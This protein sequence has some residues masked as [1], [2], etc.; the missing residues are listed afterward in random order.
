MAG[1]K[2]M[3]MSLAYWRDLAVETLRNPADAAARLMTLNLPREALW[4]A[5]VLV[6]VLNT[7]IYTLT[8][9]M[10]PAPTQIPAMLD[11]PVVFFLIVAGGL[12]LSIHAI[13]WV[14]RRLGGS[15]NLGDI[16][17]LLI[18]LQALR[19]VVQAVTLVLL[20]V[21]PVMA[22]FLVL[23]AALLGVWI[24]VH[25]INAAHQLNSLPRAAGI[26]VAS[27]LALALGLS[28]L[29]SLIGTTFLGSAGYV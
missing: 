22:A 18:W 14:G 19:V 9:I 11:N 4:T 24:L 17:L 21:A 10:V 7:L 29:L 26:L 6:A 8:N 25:F 28:F 2:S 12:F 27:I 15:G 13:F 3:I 23:A 16:L 1:G 20:I 5:L